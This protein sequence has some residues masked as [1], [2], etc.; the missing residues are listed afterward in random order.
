MGN[1]ESKGKT[2]LYNIWYNMKDRCYNER[3][4]RYKNYGGRGIKVC[5]EWHD[6]MKFKNW[7]LQNGYADNLT[8]DR[9][10]NNK[11]YS[12]DNCQW[13]TKKD[14]TAKGSRERVVSAETRRKLAE[15]HTGTN[16]I[17]SKRVRCVETN[18]VFDCISAASRTFGI[19]ERSIRKYLAGERKS[20][21]K[22]HWQYA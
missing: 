16:N 21:G 9:V 8:I 17:R 15:S 3:H 4:L 13:I 10:D 6:F 20:A 14:N 11:C 2:R 22:Y 7:A 1:K 12:P 18:Q 5:P 19:C